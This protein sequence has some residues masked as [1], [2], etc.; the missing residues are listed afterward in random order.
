MSNRPFV[1]ITLF[2][3][4]SFASIFDDLLD[5]FQLYF[6]LF[7]L[8]FEHPDGFVMTVPNLCEDGLKG[9]TLLN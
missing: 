7:D 1:A 6:G 4:S 3:R 9:G 2:C 8:Q 5:P